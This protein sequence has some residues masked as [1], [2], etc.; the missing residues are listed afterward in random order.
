MRKNGLIFVSTFLLL[1]TATA[2]I[3]G[4]VP[5]T[6]PEP[7]SMLLFGTGLVGLAGIA[8]KKKK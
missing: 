5:V 6:V 4:P 3:A 8:R 1:L 7:S 2:A